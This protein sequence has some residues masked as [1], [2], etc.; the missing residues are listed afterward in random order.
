VKNYWQ[1]S[2]KALIKRSHDLKL[3]TDNYYKILN[4]NYNKCFSEGEPVEIHLEKPTRLKEIVRYY[5]ERLGYSVTDLA[6]LLCLNED[7]M[8]RAYLDSPRIKLVVSN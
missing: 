8:R 4:I 5:M 2:I 6:A 7:D 1:V 3:I